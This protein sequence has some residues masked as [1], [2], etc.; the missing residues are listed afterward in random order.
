[1]TSSVI[2][3]VLKRK[4]E[5]AMFAAG[6]CILAS[7]VIVFSTGDFIFWKV[8]KFLYA[9]GAILIIFDR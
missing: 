8:A 2:T 6:L 9:T 5:V 1:M 7:V 3:N 4:S